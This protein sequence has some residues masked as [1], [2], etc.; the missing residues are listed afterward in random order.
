MRSDRVD[1]QG[2]LDPRLGVGDVRVGERA[3]G[4]H[5]QAQPVAE[6]H[7]GLHERPVLGGAHHQRAAVHRGDRRGAPVEEGAAGSRQLREHE[8]RRAAR[9]AARRGGRPR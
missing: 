1:G 7:G 3:P 2:R 8:A 5:G 6:L 4:A 9:R